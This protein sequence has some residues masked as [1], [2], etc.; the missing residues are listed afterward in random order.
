MTDKIELDAARVRQQVK[1]WFFRDLSDE[2]RLA[3][4]RLTMHEVPT[5]QLRTHAAQ[6]AAL[7][8]SLRQQAQPTREEV[9]EEAVVAVQ[10]PLSIVQEMIDEGRGNQST[11]ERLAAYQNAM[12]VIRALKSSP[13]PEPKQGEDGNFPALREAH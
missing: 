11:L 7:E 10:G 6:A 5:D 9:L 12:G 13:A 8:Y 3:L 1:L 2:Q 4:F